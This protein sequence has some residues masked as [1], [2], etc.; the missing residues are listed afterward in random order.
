MLVLGGTF[1]GGAL[2]EVASGAAADSGANVADFDATRVLRSNWRGRDWT[3]NAWL[4]MEQGGQTIDLG[5]GRDGALGPHGAWVVGHGTERRATDGLLRTDM[6]ALDLHGPTGEVRCPLDARAGCWSWT[7]RPDGDAVA[8]I[9]GDDGWVADARAG[10]ERVP[11][12][13]VAWLGDEEVVAHDAVV[14]VGGREVGRIPARVSL[15]GGEGAVLAVALWSDGRA[16]W[17]ID[18]AGVYPLFDGRE[19]RAYAADG[20]VCA[21]AWNDSRSVCWRPDGATVE[22]DGAFLDP[23]HLL[24]PTGHVVTELEDGRRWTLPGAERWYGGSLR[25]VAPDEVLL[26]WGGKFVRIKPDP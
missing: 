22:G 1:A 5:P 3:A 12:G 8:A 4:T 25:F 15:V 13:S 19:G 10:C 11:G 2:A 20:A 26:P 23:T 9:C 24:D 21:R 17:R 6:T 16:V 14:T 7:W 18:G